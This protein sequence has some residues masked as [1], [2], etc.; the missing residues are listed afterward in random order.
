MDPKAN[1]TKSTE[2][3]DIH[4][5]LEETPDIMPDRTLTVEE[6]ERDYQ[7]QLELLAGQEAEFKAQ[8]FGSSPSNNERTPD[9]KHVRR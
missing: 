8:R 4:Q 1:V 5:E 7:S 3:Q 2:P 6:A 9:K